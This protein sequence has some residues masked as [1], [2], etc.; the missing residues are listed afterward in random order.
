LRHGDH[1][2]VPRR[3]RR[4]GAQGAH[5]AVPAAGHTARSS[6]VVR[7]SS[8]AVAAALTTVALT[9]TAA[10]SFTGDGGDAVASAAEKVAQPTAQPVA[11]TSAVVTDPEVRSASEKADAVLTDADYVTS[12][13]DLNSKERRKLR[14]ATRELRGIVSQARDAAVTATALRQNTAAS[15]STERTSLA[16]RA[17]DAS[18]GSATADDAASDTAADATDPTN[19]AVVSAS[20]T[21]LGGQQTESLPILATPLADSVV[22]TAAAQESEQAE[23]S[24]D[25]E[26]AQAAAE[27]ATAAPSAD[28]IEKVTTSLQRLITKTDGDAVVSVKPG[29]TPEEIAAAK[30]AAEERREARA[31]RRAERKAEEARE[32]AAARAKQM[33]KAAKN[34]GNGQIPSSVL[35]GLSFAKGEQLR[36]DAAVALEDLNQAFRGK[37]GRNLQLT[38]GYRS[39]GEQ[40]AVA[41]SR[42]ALAAVPGTSNHGL[43]QAVDL[44]GGIQSFGS[45]Q[46]RWMQANAG[47]F[48]WKHPGWAQAGGS[49]PEAWHWEY[50]T[51]Y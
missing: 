23:K 18:A 10:V 13:G 16:D 38:D 31:E 44:S 14:A 9:T 15:R 33:A 1:T 24:A 12:E 4:P 21:P 3:T 26:A 47:K 28:R 49:K 19:L 37:F 51:K 50:G 32:K 42:G 45:A 25:A 43:G 41:A 35:C 46:F 48:G 40:V 34:Y 11:I 8:F 6:R 29:P 5:A 20:V 7:R 17:A 36:C 30:K 2:L 27:S 39:Y 22:S